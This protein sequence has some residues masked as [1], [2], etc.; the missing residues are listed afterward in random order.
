MWDVVR[1][2]FAAFLEPME[3]KV[4]WMY[5]DHL[6]LVT[7]GIGNLIDSEDAAWATRDAG[8]PFVHKRDESVEAS[9]A[10]VRDEWRR[11]KGDPSL[12]GKWHQAGHATTLKLTED[13]IQAL[14]Q[15]TL[16]DFES[17][18]LRVTEFSDLD[19]WPADA[20]LA[21]FSMAWAMGPAFAN[22]G[23]WPNFRG[24]CASHDWAAATTHCNMANSWTARRNAVNRGLFRNAAWVASASADSSRLYIVIPGNRPTLQLHATDSDHAGKGFD[25]DTS[26][27]TLQ[28]FLQWLGYYG[29]A[30]NGD[31]DEETDRAV[32][33]FQQDEHD[34]TKK[35]GGFDVDGIVGRQTW[36]ALGYV[37]PRP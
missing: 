5:Q 7:V 4:A 3:A 12:K 13:G 29:G 18:L 16:A 31:F 35:M 21:L 36:A 25:D 14:L 33:A 9:E 15:R 27:S 22:G 19:E 26:V 28:T 30:V 8:A 2:S 17:A 10:E 6:G 24:A 1:D 23:K 34:L 32:R 37:V 11:V 20:Q